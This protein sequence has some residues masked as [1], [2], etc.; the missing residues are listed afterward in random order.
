MI[1]MQSNCSAHNV[2]RNVSELFCEAVFD[3]YLHWPATKAGTL[4][5]KLCPFYDINK[6]RIF[7]IS[8]LSYTERYSFAQ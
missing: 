5:T 2:C 7:K 8:N 1:K 3:G 6:V 4:T